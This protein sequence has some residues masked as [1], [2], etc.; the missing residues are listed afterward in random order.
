MKRDQFLFDKVTTPF[1]EDVA[2]VTTIAH[3][4]EKGLPKYTLIIN[5]GP[6]DGHTIEGQGQAGE[7]THKAWVERHRTGFYDCE[8]CDGYGVVEC[9]SDR[10]VWGSGG[11]AGHTTDDWTEPCDECED[12][13]AWDEDIHPD[14]EP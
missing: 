14:G 8:T 7:D 9:S 4:Q 3:P 13:K 6:Y 12:G 1:G 11:I 5:G 2:L 10:V